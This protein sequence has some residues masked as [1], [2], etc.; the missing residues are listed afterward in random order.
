[1]SGIKSRWN[2]AL[3]GKAGGGEEWDAFR[4]CWPS[5]ADAILGIKNEKGG[6]EV[7]PCKVLVF[8]EADRLKFMLSPSLGDLVAFGTFPDVTGG[9]DG[10]EQELT[11]GAYEWKKRRR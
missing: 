8:A 6:W 10:L 2:E 4:K 9:F 5:L 11:K 1:M 3:A 7:P